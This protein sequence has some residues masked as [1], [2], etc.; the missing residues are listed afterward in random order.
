MSAAVSAGLLPVTQIGTPGTAEAADVVQAPPTAFL[1]GDSYVENYQQR[2]ALSCEFAAT[3][4][5]LRLL[6]LNV[7]EDVMIGLV[8]KGEDPDET[9]RGEIHANQNLNDYGIHARGIA[10]AVELARKNGILP[11]S[12]ST[13]LLYSLD[14]VRLAI[15]AGH[16]VV[17]WQPL[18]LRSS[19][20]VPVT[21]STGKVVTLVYAE[22]AITLRGYD[23]THFFVLE[24]HAGAALTYEANALWRAM[25]LF[26]DPALAIIP[27]APPK[28]VPTSLYFPETGVLLDGG[29]FRFWTEMGGR[30]TLGIPLIPERFEPGGP[31][32][33]RQVIY[34]QT[35][36]MEWSPA[37]GRF[38]LGFAGQDYL[39]DEASPN[40]ARRLEGAIARFVA[41]NGGLARFGASISEEVPI[42]A[43]DNN[44]LPVPIVDGIG[45]WFQTGLLVWSRATGVI[46][47][48]A[49]LALARK[50]GLIDVVESME[51]AQSAG[52]EGEEVAGASMAAEGLE[53]PDDEGDPA[54]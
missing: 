19:S 24:P 7:P 37:T 48:T 30:E 26:D 22:H 21:L 40:P 42:A 38:T 13:Q 50:N 53:A 34:T 25:S 44:L 2:W 28:P 36:R 23:A 9:F 31:G 15:A 16:P 45:Q 5:A 17:A 33:G 51:V 14:E 27:Q 43:D 46:Y 10:R 49:G 20:R 41:Q 12:L 4:T 1:P 35:G 3:H 29:F 39:G 47:G 52:G 54:G 32:G 11:E 6:G 18:D 8:G